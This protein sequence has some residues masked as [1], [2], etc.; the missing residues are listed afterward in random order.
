[1]AEE[2]WHQVLEKETM[3]TEKQREN[4]MMLRQT[5]EE[6][7][8]IVLERKRNE[9]LKAELEQLRIIFDEEGERETAMVDQM[10]RLAAREQIII[11]DE[12]DFKLEQLNWEKEKKKQNREN[13]LIKEESAEE[14][15]KLEEQLLDINDKIML[16]EQE[17]AQLTEQWKKLIQKER[18][19]ENNE[20]FV[21]KAV[22]A[23]ANDEIEVLKGKLRRNE[24]ALE[25]KKAENRQLRFALDETK[26]MTIQQIS[27][28]GEKGKELIA[29]KAQL[30]EFKS[31]FDKLVES[32]LADKEVEVERLHEQL[33]LVHEAARAETDRKIASKDVEIEQLK[34]ELLKMRAM[35]HTKLSNLADTL[36]TSENR[37]QWLII[38]KEKDDFRKEKDRFS[39]LQKQWISQMRGEMTSLNSAN[40][41]LF[42]YRNDP[43]ISE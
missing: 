32:R 39:R 13:K 23:K 7:E 2:K 14:R 21:D 4:E 34:K 41:K 18:E 11:Q 28:F 42:S 27:D 15:K 26:T 19:I 1:L 12:E 8:Q 37:S 16:H 24:E 36:L 33:R 9:Q 29:A 10:D 6:K 17:E 20:N 30:Q 43:I 38:Q 31:N 22:L 40:T 35:A 25:S 5:D 3:I